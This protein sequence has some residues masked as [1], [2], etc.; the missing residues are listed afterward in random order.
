M[1]DKRIIGVFVV[2]SIFS[3]STNLFLYDLNEE[4]IALLEEKESEIQAWKQKHDWAVEFS[5]LDLESKEKVFEN[6]IP[7][8]DDFRP[9]L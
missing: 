8:P 5:K 1:V 3:L 2:F 4:K 7:D 6:I 9:Q